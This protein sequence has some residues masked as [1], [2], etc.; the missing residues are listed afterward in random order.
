MKKLVQL[1]SGP[2]L[3]PDEVKRMIGGLADELALAPCES[4]GS[5]PELAELYRRGGGGLRHLP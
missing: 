3:E 2:A 1:P 5:L 4:L